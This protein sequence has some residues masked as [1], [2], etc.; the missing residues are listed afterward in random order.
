MS[1]LNVLGLSF[2]CRCDIVS[3]FY[4]GDAYETNDTS[5]G[6]HW[7]SYWHRIF[8][9]RLS[10]RGGNSFRFGKFC[11]IRLKR[12]SADPLGEMRPGVFGPI[13]FTHRMIAL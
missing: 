12:R 4:K 5:F 13:V 9:V 2:F 1:F 7:C 8:G 6:N 10:C 3:T 11:A